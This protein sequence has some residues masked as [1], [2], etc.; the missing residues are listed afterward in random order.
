MVHK[1]VKVRLYQTLEQQVLLSQH[2]GCARWWWNYALNKSIET[3]KE[4]GK[5]LGQSALNAFLPKLKKAEETIWLSECYS[6]VLQ[7]TTLNLTTA[8]KNFFAGRARFPRYKSKHGKQSIQYPQNVKVLDGFVQFP[9]KVGKVKAKLHRKIEG[10]IKTVTVSLDPSG[11]YFSSILTEAEGENPTVSTD[12]KVIG[13]DLGLTH[14]AITS[15]GSKI[16]KYNNP[17]HLAKHEKN[18]K[19]KQQKLAKKQKGSNSRNKAKKTVAKVYER[20]TK[21]RQ[22]FLHKLS[23][24]LVN[25][26]QVVVVENL[27]VKGMVRNLNL[28]KAISDVGWGTFVNFLAYKLENKGGKLVEIDR[29]FPSSKLCSN[30]YYQID[31]LPLD[32]REWT[33]PNC[34][35]RH[36]RD[37]NA[38]T[39]IRAEGIRMLQTDGTAVSANGGEVRPKLGRKS[40]L[41]HSPTMLEAYIIV[42]ST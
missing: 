4:T 40:V 28:A 25:E 35:T 23:R 39:N 18:L 20:V 29:W 7:A 8:Y 13:V 36:D 26:N 1:A 3:Y 15:D 34:G 41:R 38:A 24:K 12:G 9:G 21:S 17:K 42:A 33:C 2:F 16:S 31:K 5:S 10:T 19:R 11:K 30:C 14:F 32:V 37:G 27:N 6:Q 22:D